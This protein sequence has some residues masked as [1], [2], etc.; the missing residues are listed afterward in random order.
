MKAATEEGAC[1]ECGQPFTS[2]RK[3]HHLRHSRVAPKRFCSETCRKRAE[4][5]RR[6]ERQG[7]SDAA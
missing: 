5:R 6:R 2:A 3:P 1:K 4:S 7:A